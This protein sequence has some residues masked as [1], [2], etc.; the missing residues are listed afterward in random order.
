MLDAIVKR[1]SVRS[2]KPDPVPEEAL[3]AICEA[4]FSA[5][6]ANN[7]RPWHILVVGDAE[8]REA[9]SQVHQYA[10]FCAQ[11]PLVLVMCGDPV[12][13]EP[14]WIEDCCAATENAMIQ[15]ADL[16]LGTCWVGIRGDDERGFER[17]EKVR[18]IL[19][20]PEPIR[21]LCLI[22]LGYPLDDGHN[23]GPGPMENVHRE[24][25]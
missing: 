4:A 22:P 2:Y 24:Q 20:I 9:L 25:W 16:G 13:A 3:Q 6:A 18:A 11:A 14:W 21:V 1:R 15:A 23:R 10:G 19:G 5:P 8:K 7:R 12:L 17:E